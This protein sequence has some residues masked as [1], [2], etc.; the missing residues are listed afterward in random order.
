MWHRPTV[1][2]S[3]LTAG[4]GVLDRQRMSTV[5]RTVLLLLCALLTLVESIGP[6]AERVDDIGRLTALMSIAIV[7]VALATAF[8][9]RSWVPV[10]ESA[11]VTL[12][13]MSADGPHEAVLPYL[14]APALD[15]GLIAGVRGAVL[16]AGASSAMVLVARLIDVTQR[17][18]VGYSTVAAEWVM[19]ALLTG[20]LA[21]WARRLGLRTAGRDEP[22][23]AAYRLVSQLRTVSRQLSGGLDA[24]GLSLMLLEH[25]RTQTAYDRAAVF[26][27]GPAGTLIPLESD[28]HLPDWDNSLAGDGVMAEAW[29]QQRPVT[30]GVGLNGTTGM[31]SLAL[32]LTVGARTVG[33]VAAERRGRWEFEDAE[34]LMPAIEDAALRIETALLFGE[35]RAIATADER[36]RLAREIH[37]GIAQELAFLGYVLDDV[38]ARSEQPDLAG[39]LKDL[40]A[41]ITRVVGDLRL[42][43]FELRSEVH[44][45]AGLGS[46]LSDFV[47]S[48]GTM[49]PMTVHLALDESPTRLPHESEAELLRIAQESVNNARKHSSAENLWVTCS[50]HPP[51]ALLVVEDDGRGLQEARRDSYG[52]QIMKER[53]DRLGARLSI[54]DRPGGGTRVEVALGEPS[55]HRSASER[56]MSTGP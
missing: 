3:A 24:V 25:L 5:A 8:P 4:V 10:G 12:L 54:V 16:V 2:I 40:R 38:S 41:Q 48:I 45:A 17:D 26:V 52:L 34:L 1:A 44:H 19:L 7:A 47:R 9:R 28:G 6:R 21:A 14:L 15:A 55:A 35:V 51:R 43:I 27:P 39:E 33:V 46:V 42:S 20:V 23:S 53:A 31:V 32:P 13:V 49:T 22:Y 50:V 36:K 37:D 30:A 56:E 29:S 11:A 18:L